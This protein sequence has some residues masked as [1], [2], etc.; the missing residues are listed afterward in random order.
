LLREPIEA[1]RPH[2]WV[3]S[4]LVFVPILTAHA[5]TD[6]SSW[7]GSVLMFGAFC[8][9]AS[10]ICLINDLIDI[11]ADRTDPLKHGR[12]FARGALSLPVGVMA[13]LVLLTGGLCLVELGHVGWIIVLYAAM[14]IGYSFRL[15]ELSLVDV[16]MPAGLYTIRLFGGGEAT[17]HKLRLWLL[18]F[19][20]FLFLSLA[21]LRRVEEMMSLENSG[22]SRSKT[23]RRGYLPANIRVLQLF[24]AGA[25]FASSIVLSLFVQNEGTAQIYASSNLLWL[26]VPLLLFWQCRM[27]LSGACG[28]MHHDP[29]VYAAKDRISW[30]IG[31][32]VSA[33]L[34]VAKSCPWFGG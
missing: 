28:Y 31:A 8:S 17:G 34:I 10:A 32:S 30:A 18:A 24:G 20:S 3:K 4:V 7:I 12:P 23:G 25:A 2:Q 6:V 22:G 15:K 9:T 11:N 13:A 1:M 26:C 16:Y 29:I 5:L 14:S 33:A 27:W 19:S 21:L